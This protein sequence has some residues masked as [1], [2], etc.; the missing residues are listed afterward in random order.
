MKATPKFFLISAMSILAMSVSGH[1]ATITLVQSNDTSGQSWLTP[2]TW[3]NNAVPSS[4]NDYVVTSPSGVRTVRTPQTANVSYTFGGNSLTI[5]NSRLLFA[6]LMG[7]NITI[8]NFILTN[9]GMMSNGTDALQ[10]LS[11]GLEISGSAFARLSTLAT[12]RNITIASQIT[13]SGSFG[14]I[15]NGTLTLNGTGNTFTGTWTVGGT[16]VTIPDGTYS[17]TSTLISTLIGSSTGSLGVNSNVTLNIWSRFDLNYD[18]TT[19]GTLTLASNGGSATAIVMTLDQNVTVGNLVVAGNTLTPG[20]YDYSAL[21]TA[22]FSDYFTNSGGSITV[23]PEPGIAG[24]LAFS[25]LGT[26]VWLR[27]ARRL[28]V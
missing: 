27:R 1:A 12:V 28:R 22:G 3:S 19:T 5:N 6:T 18:W 13:G 7:S 15:Q 25:T 14:L 21:S 8:G 26:V 23:V 2:G 9:N 17:N 20:T 4:L 11:G 10:T 24:L 16:G